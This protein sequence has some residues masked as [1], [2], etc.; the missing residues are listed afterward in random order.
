MRRALRRLLIVALLLL[1]AFL[2]LQRNLNRLVLDTADARAVALAAEVLSRTVRESTAGGVPYD[3]L[4]TVRTDEAGRVTL[5]QADT[6][7]MNELATTIA[8]AAQEAL[9]REAPAVSVPLGVALGIPLLSNLGPRV[10]V[11]MTPVGAVQAD[12]ATEFEA[13]GINQ[14]RHKIYLRLRAVVRLVLPAGAKA[15]T[16]E[17]S[18]LIAESIIVGQVPQSFVQV[19]E[20]M[21]DFG[22]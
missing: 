8:L 7:R 19:P 15:V 20:G 14:T 10:R 21:L 1:A 17:T 18:V 13:A 5:L 22:E 12:F 6:A 3:R 9:S 2:L 11:T 16:A 4:M